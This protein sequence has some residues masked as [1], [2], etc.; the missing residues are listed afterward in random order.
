MEKNNSLKIIAVILALAL[1][2]TCFAAGAAAAAPEQ[3]IIPGHNYYFSTFMNITTD[4]LPKY[5]KASFDYDRDFVGIVPEYPGYEDRGF[6]FP[7]ANDFGSI[8]DVKYTVNDTIITYEYTL[9]N[10]ADLG[11]YLDC[12]DKNREAEGLS[13]LPRKEGALY[14]FV[15]FEVALKE[16][17]VVPPQVVTFVNRLDTVI[18]TDGTFIV[19]DG[20]RIGKCYSQSGFHMTLPSL[21]PI[22]TEPPNPFDPYAHYKEKF[23]E[24]YNA[25]AGSFEV[26]YEH[27]A[28][29]DE[30]D[31]ALVKVKSVRNDIDW[32]NYLELG[33]RVMSRENGAFYPFSF[34][35]GIYSA[36]LGRYKDL[37]YGDDHEYFPGLPRIWDEIGF[38]RLIGD[39]DNDDSLTVVDAT[40]MQ[41]CAV[42][43]TEYPQN[44]ENPAESY[45]KPSVSSFFDFDRDGECDIVDATALQRYL[46]YLPYMIHYTTC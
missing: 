16:K 32:V 42:G 24:Q 37:R 6:I 2:V 11:D 19:K 23:E 3:D 7:L 10:G 36:K 45:S 29:N 14:T 31:W 34:D 46:T 40:V 35:V 13:K 21:E 27:K 15:L 41:R 17:V 5:I 30:V 43:I 26:L 44:G 4:G 39:I 12:V 38:G 9:K 33:N 1:I 28:T 25:V 18:K 20:E 22:A 8:Y